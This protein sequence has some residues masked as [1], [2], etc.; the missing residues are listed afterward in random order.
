M[1]SNMASGGGLILGG[2]AAM[3]FTRGGGTPR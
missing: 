3:V 2:I 1:R